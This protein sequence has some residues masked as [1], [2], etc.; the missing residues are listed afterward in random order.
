MIHLVD[1]LNYIDKS[2]DTKLCGRNSQLRK[3]LK[4]YWKTP[5]INYPNTL[6]IFK[7]SKSKDKKWV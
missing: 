7:I 1:H 5:D 3:V 6:K 4:S 2:W